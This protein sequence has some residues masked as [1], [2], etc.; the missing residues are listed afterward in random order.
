MGM[1]DDVSALKSGVYRIDLGNGR[2]YL[3]SACDLVKR[4]REHR[5]GL[6]RGDHCN[7]IMQ[8]AF[9]KYGEFSFRV[10][11]RY[12]VDEILRR[13][14]DLLDEHHSDPRCANVAVT[15]GSP[16]KGRKFSAQ[17]RARMSTAN[18]GRKHTD[19][20]RANMS[21]AQMGKKRPPR[22]PE[23]RAAQSAALTGRKYTDETRAKMSAA[24]AGMK[25]SPEHRAKIGAAL[26]GRNRTDETRAKISA[27][28]AARWARVRESAA[29]T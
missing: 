22:T 5:R 16:N 9:N 2:F 18:R 27:G 20:A 24:R 13:E 10:L 11:G 28:Q 6:R 15:A 7:Q 29:T 1:A 17:H 19:E 3:G 12:P 23:H 8:R 21:A 25:L 4:E 14:Q 26:K